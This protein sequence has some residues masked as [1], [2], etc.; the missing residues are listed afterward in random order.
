M[1]STVAEAQPIQNQRIVSTVLHHINVVDKE[2]NLISISNDDSDLENYLTDLLKEVNNKTQKR[3]YDFHRETT[4]FFTTLKSF[5][6]QQN[7]S[8]NPLSSNLAS[9]LL[10][11]EVETDDRY[12]HLGSSGNGH[13]KKGSFLQFLYR[14]GT[15]ISYLG[16]KIEHQIFL[17][18]IDFK[19]KIGL[20]VAN[21]IYKACKVSFDSE[22]MPFSVFVFDTNSKPS[23]YWWKDFLELKEVRDNALN[24][25]VASQEVIKVINRIKNDHPIDYTILRNSVIAAFK[26]QS[27][28][29]YDV[30]LNNT[31][32]NYE[33][34]DI[35]LKDKIPKLLDTLNELPEKKKFDTHFNLVP[36][37]VPFNHSKVTLSKEISLTI[38]DGINNL[39]EKIWSEQSACGKKL[40]V[41][42]SP[43]GFKRFT[44]KERI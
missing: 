1:E 20:S 35:N 12:G 10:D 5:F 26:Q 3:A 14:E 40:V 15:D 29:K 21:K 38:D 39:E 16:V 24:T 37:E 7:L 4:E 41:I 36:S 32:E 2:Y 9:R 23:T 8:E 34:V 44:L 25:R 27:E 19:K 33:P 11:K 6:I 42:E 28:M 18:E 17:D 43:E 30:F 31:F 13:V 22:G